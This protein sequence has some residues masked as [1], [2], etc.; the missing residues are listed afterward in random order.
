MPLHLPPDTWETMSKAF[1]DY[2]GFIS[3]DK[4]IIKTS[5]PDQNSTVLQQPC[6]LQLLWR[7]SL[8]LN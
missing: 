4:E 6:L 3:A 1:G 5:V 8:L 7:E 2:W